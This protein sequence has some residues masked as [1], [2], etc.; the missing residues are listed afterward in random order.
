MELLQGINE[1][2]EQAYNQLFKDF[3]PSLV[4]FVDKFVECTDESM[5]IAQE[6][7]VKLYTSNEVFASV[8]RVKSYLYVLAR[9]MAVNQLRH[10]D[11]ENKW[12]EFQQ[13]EMTDHLWEDVDEEE[14]YAM[15]YKAIDQLPPQSRRIILLSLENHSNGEIAQLLGLSINSVNTLKKNAYKKLRILLKDYFIYLFLLSLVEK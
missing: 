8:D 2:Q 11:V 14:I 4:M 5:D 9:N 1:K 13:T 3:F 6:C 15:V 10:L 7:F 12:I